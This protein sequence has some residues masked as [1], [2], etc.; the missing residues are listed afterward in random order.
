MDISTILVVASKAC[1]ALRVPLY[2]VI[3]DLS[4]NSV[5]LPLASVAPL[6]TKLVAE[7]AGVFITA[8]PVSVF[9]AGHPSIHR[10]T[11]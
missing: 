8:L 4:G 2:Q 11:A 7:V 5:Y 1:R 6:Q 9:M 3:V 10:L